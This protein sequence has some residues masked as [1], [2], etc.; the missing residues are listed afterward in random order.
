MFNSPSS[1]ISEKAMKQIHSKTIEVL[2]CIGL[3]VMY[4]GY[5]P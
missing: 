2:E 5:Y 4:E 1:V 3:K